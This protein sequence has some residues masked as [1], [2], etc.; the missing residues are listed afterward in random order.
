MDSDPRDTM[1]STDL[2]LR[3]LADMKTDMQH[4]FAGLGER[5]DTLNGRTRLAETNI[6][7]L[8][9]RTAKMVCA[10]HAADLVAITSDHK[11][12]LSDNERFDATLDHLS[13]L[14][15]SVQALV[16]A[17]AKSHARTSMLTGTV[18][19]VLLAC[20]EGVWMWLGKR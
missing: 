8:N 4:G 14:E 15:A 10:A 3:M 2:I 20:A 18:V 17:P 7:L 5:L 6:A 16:E 13:G 9:E 12:L 19:A 1:E 11:R